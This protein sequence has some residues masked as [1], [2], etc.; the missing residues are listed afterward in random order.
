[1]MHIIKPQ[2]GSS[3]EPI[4]YELIAALAVADGFI[5]IVLKRILMRA[6]PRALPNGKM[7]TAAGRWFTA[8]LI[9]LA[10]SLST[11]MF[12]LVLHF[13]GAPERQ[14]QALVVLGILFMFVSPGKLPAETT[15]STPFG[16]VG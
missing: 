2:G 3:A 1:M 6:K 14:A 11:C 13:I 12:G 5:G 7:P 9:R 15:E 8:N 16:T 10:F 4:V